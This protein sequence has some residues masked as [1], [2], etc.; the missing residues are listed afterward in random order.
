MKRFAGLLAKSGA[1]KQNDLDRDIVQSSKHFNAEWYR[2]RYMNS[3]KLSDPIEHFLTVGS[4]RSFDPGPTFSAHNY[5]S[6]NPDVAE[7]DFNAL[8]HYE[9]FGRAEKRPIIASSSG[10]P[11]AP[12]VGKVEGYKAGAIV[13]WAVDRRSSEQPLQVDF[14]IGEIRLGSIAADEPRGDLKRARISDSVGGFAFRLPYSPTGQA[15]V[16]IDVRASGKAVTGSPAKIKFAKLSGFRDLNCLRAFASARSVSIVIAVY[17]AA[18]EFRRCV[19]AVL[20]QTTWPARLVIVD[21]ASPDPRIAEICNSLRDVEGVTV[22]RNL[23]N[24]GYT[25]TINRGIEASEDCDIVLL[26]SDTIVTPR[27]LENLVLAAYD[28]PQVGTVTPL[29][30][31][32]GAFSVPDPGVPNHTPRGLDGDGYARSFTRR[33]LAAYPSS[34]TGSGFCMFIKQICVRD[35]GLFD[36]E[37]F[38]R[39]YGEENDY[40]MRLFRRGWINRIDDR[41]LIF[42]ARSA[43]FGDSRAGLVQAGRAI[44][45]E[46]YPEYRQLVQRFVQSGGLALAQFRARQISMEPVADV[47]KPRILFVISTETGG[48]PQTNMDLMSGVADEYEPWLLKCTG[49][50]L[51]LS[52]LEKDELVAVDQQGF[53]PAVEAFTHQSRGY[54]EVVARW[55]VQYQIELLHVRHIAWHSLSLMRLAQAMRI[56]VAFS[57]HDFYSICP[58]VKLLDDAM[59]FCGGKC[60]PGDG[61]CMP[62]L[63]PASQLEGLKHNRVYHWRSMMSSALEH[64]DAFVT[65]TSE[66]R[67]IVSRNIPAVRT[68]EFAIIPHGRTF[69]SFR[70]S[71]QPAR[72]RAPIKVL[73]LGNTSRAKGAQLFNEIKAIDVDNSIEFHFLGATESS[74]NRSIGIFHGAYDRDSVDDLIAG[75]APNFAAILSIWPETYC[76]TLTEC[77]A[78]GLPVLGLDVGAVGERIRAHNG[79]WLA[80]LASTPAELMRFMQE[81]GANEADFNQ[82]CRAVR[83]WQVTIGANQTVLAMAS[84]Y[85]TLYRKI[86]QTKRV[87]RLRAGDGSEP[88][89][90]ERLQ[91]A[92]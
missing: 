83:R 56:P 24:K 75:I 59:Q 89:A 46:R 19:D 50:V 91:V 6:A 57:F 82:R 42:H 92:E 52:R 73:V 85:K 86:A 76:H 8:V 11:T 9:R 5:M 34:P 15:E 79:G 78:A 25:A 72:P 36:V 48:T 71:A 39:G 2:N 70:Q 38:P 22:L 12:L 44:V 61:S 80:P 13:G 7:T 87:F 58:T 4:K 47:P 43:S 41:T 23:S 28:I 49:S 30:N 35:V 26:N 32:A 1:K 16:S 74:L 68:K 63:W 3:S 18:D 33:S 67:A 84:E 55:L 29:S 20:N 37:A 81:I 40:C 51:S 90:E 77:W 45:D 65:T 10:G 60:T 66:A 31:N 88:A 62:E 54:D 14:F 21:D 53:E 69:K 17:N 27:W 64:C